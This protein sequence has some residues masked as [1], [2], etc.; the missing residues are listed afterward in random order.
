[1]TEVNK[2]NYF[3]TISDER[4][5]IFSSQKIAVD[6]S[7][8][9]LSISRKPPWATGSGGNGIIN[10]TNKPLQFR[11]YSSYDLRCYLPYFCL[12]IKSHASK[13][14]NNVEVS[15]NYQQV[16]IPSN[17]V[18]A[19][20]RNAYLRF[21][22]NSEMAEIYNN[23]KIGVA[24]VTRMLKT[25]SRTELENMHECHFT[26]YFETEG[27]DLVS[28]LT[29]ES[30]LRSR[31]WLSTES[32]NNTAGGIINHSKMLKLADL[33]S[34]CAAVGYLQIN[35]ID[36]VLELN[37]YNDILFQTSADANANHYII[38]DIS[39]I[40]DQVKMTEAQASLELAEIKKGKNEQ[41]LS[42]LYYDV[43]VQNYIKDSRIIIPTVEHLQSMCWMFPSNIDGQGI[44]KQQ[45]I[46]NASSYLVKYGNESSTDLPVYIDLSQ[47]GTQTNTEL[48][49]YYRKG[50]FEY[51]SNFTPAIHPYY[52]YLF[53]FMSTSPV[54]RGENNAIMWMPLYPNAQAFHLT[55][56][57]RE[58]EIYTSQS[59]A[60]TISPC[61][62]YVILVRMRCV[63]IQPDS[64]VESIQ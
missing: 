37:M 20:I 29:V 27:R 30:A 16:S 41:H 39:L 12:V 11:V 45:F 19:L 26:P 5:N 4:Y 54:I 1:M 14:V 52:G 8:N 61:I 43:C 10:Y 3:E 62:C 60:G 33:F 21:N 57:G 23:Q 56:P 7:S 42:F 55:S 49:Y 24:N 32:T 48:Y 64:T 40:V 9:K 59:G 51:T 47:N 34:S 2:E 25:K 31:R 36:I 58:L 53:P 38:D 28:G 18:M 17:I 13:I 63:S 15:I 44:N 50:G 22:S 35:T 6:A 46:L